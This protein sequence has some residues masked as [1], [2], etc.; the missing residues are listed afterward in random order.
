MEI[1][2]KDF[3]KVSE[4]KRNGYTY[5]KVYEDEKYLVWRMRKPEEVHYSVEVWKKILFKNPDGQVVVRSLRDEEF[6]VYGWYL[7]GK[8][9][10][11]KR[12]VREKFGI[13][14]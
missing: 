11:V 12:Q 6:G 4:F 10:E 9:P 2:R 7:V 1:F 5:A 14:L 8:E 13:A 3:S